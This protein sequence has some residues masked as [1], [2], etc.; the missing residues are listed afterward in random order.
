M[1]KRKQISNEQ[2]YDP[3]L[4]LENESSTQQKVANEFGIN[5]ATFSGWKKRND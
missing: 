4:R 1:T 5:K 2:K 3:I